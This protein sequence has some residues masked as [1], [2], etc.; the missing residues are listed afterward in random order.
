MLP[1]CRFLRKTGI[2][3]STV[4]ELVAAEILDIFE[5]C[6]GAYRKILVSKVSF[7][8]FLKAT[9]LRTLN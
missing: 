3:R 8:R 7:I 2:A 1:L 6:P 9:S 4:L 5:Y